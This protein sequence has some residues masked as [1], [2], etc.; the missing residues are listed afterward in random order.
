MKS[1][2]KENWRFGF[3]GS[4]KGKEMDLTI[5]IKKNKNGVFL[6][7]LVFCSSFSKR[8]KTI[9]I[10]VGFNLSG[11]K[12]FLSAR[13][14]TLNIGP[15][16]SIVVIKRRHAVEKIVAEPVSHATVEELRNVCLH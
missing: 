9:C 10:P 4:K 13:E 15:V 8:L 3:Q 12:L 14:W 5:N 11:W 6:S 16:D 2:V 7:L 1:F